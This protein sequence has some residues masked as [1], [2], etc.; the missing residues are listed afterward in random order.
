MH[1][2]AKEG[3][4][5]FVTGGWVSADEAGTHYI[6]IVNEITEGH[7]WL[8]RNLGV[9]PR[10]GYMRITCSLT[11]ER[12]RWSI[13]PFGH[14]SVIPYILSQ[15]G[16]EATVINRVHRETKEKFRYL[17]SIYLINPFGGLTSNSS[18]YGDKIGS[19][20]VN[21]SSIILLY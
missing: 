3:R 17:R 12:T 14:S 9:K 10:V 7:E 19:T 20:K 4:F 21:C 18:L 8:Q 2:I 1:R 6:D 11:F 16:L 13:D 15:M 5:E